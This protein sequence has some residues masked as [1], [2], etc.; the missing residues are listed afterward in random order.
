MEERVP[1]YT[2]CG[3][4]FYSTT[5]YGNHC[6]SRTHLENDEMKLKR[7]RTEES[8]QKSAQISENIEGH[9]APHD[10]DTATDAY[11]TTSGTDSQATLYQPTQIIDLTGG[12]AQQKLVFD[13]DWTDLITQNANVADRFV[14][15]ILKLVHKLPCDTKHIPNRVS[16]ITASMDDRLQTYRHEFQGVPFHCSNIIECIG[17]L[18]GRDN[19]A[20]R[21]QWEST[22]DQGVF[23]DFT[24]GQ[25]FANVAQYYGKFNTKVLALMLHSDSTVV[26]Q[27]GGR[28]CHPITLSF[29]NLPLDECNKTGN[30]ITVGYFPCNIPHERRRKLQIYHQCIEKLLEPIA[31]QPLILYGHGE[32]GHRCVPLLAHW[33]GDL[34]E[35][36]MLCNVFASWN[37]ALRPCFVCDKLRE[38]F[39]DG[40]A[41]EPR[42]VEAVKRDMADASRLASKERVDLEKQRSMYLQKVCMCLRTR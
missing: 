6:R 19:V 36:A 3:R 29:G 5:A 16:D 14:N 33:A 18:L 22:Y 42:T 37:K 15:Q 39:H 31:S 1:L 23:S 24:S 40:T 12:I 7:R 28:A 35:K 27:F 11:T 32:H 41:G 20:N 4:K 17:E 13:K 21:L 25:W 2:C 9:A 26:S 10:D 38:D 8:A 34:P 30:R